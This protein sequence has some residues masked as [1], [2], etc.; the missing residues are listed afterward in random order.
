MEEG[1]WNQELR[2]SI[3]SYEDVNYWRLQWDCHE[4][5]SQNCYGLGT[6]AFLLKCFFF[7]CVLCKIFMLK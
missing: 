7:V 5:C 1:L 2:V 6:C 3:L 4:E